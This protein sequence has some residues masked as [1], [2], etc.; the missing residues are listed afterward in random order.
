M[1]STTIFLLIFRQLKKTYICKVEYTYH[2]MKRVV[3]IALLFSTVSVFAQSKA[4]LDTRW[5]ID[6]E[7]NSSAGQKNSDEEVVEMLAQVTSDFR[8]EEL[9]DHGIRIGSRIGNVVTLR[10]KPSQ[11]SILDACDHVIYYQVSHT[12]VPECNDTRFDTRTDSVQAGYGLPQGYDGEGV[13]IGI[14]DWG[15]D[16][17]HPNYNGGGQDN[18]RILRA[19]DHFRHAGPAPEGFDYGTELVGSS[20]LRAAQCDTSGIYGY[21]T[22]GTH[23]TGI[24]A[25]RGI[26][27]IKYTG[28]APKANLLMCSFNLGENPWLDAVAWMKRVADEEGKRLVINS[29]WGMYSF[30]TLDGTSLVSQAIDSY[31]DSG[32]VFVTSAGNNGGTPFHL[33]HEFEGTD[34]TLRSV[35][36][37]YSG[38][39]GNMLIMWGE[40]GERFEAAVG[41]E[42]NDTLIISPFYATDD[43]GYTLDTFLIAGEDTARFIVMWEAENRL[44][45]RPHMDIKVLQQPHVTWHL[46]IHA[47]S[48]FVHAWNLNVQH[49]NAGN[50]GYEFESRN[51]PGY[52]RGDDNYGISE[53]G[54][55]QKAISVAAHQADHYNTIT[56]ILQIG[57][58]ASFSSHGPIMGGMRKPEVSAPGVNVISSLSSFTTETGHTIYD[59]AISGGRSYPFGSMSGTSMSSPAV[60]GVVALILQANPNLTTDQVREILFTT[61]RNDEMTG[62]IH[63]AGELSYI[64][65]WGKVDAYHAVLAAINMLS[66]DEQAEKRM[67]PTAFPNPATNR[68]TLRT[69]STQP[70]QVTICSIDGRIVWNGTANCETVLDLTGWEHGVYIVNVMDN[71]RNYSVKFVKQ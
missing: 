59:N 23:V 60:T 54:C 35:V 36:H 8:F 48:G 28:Q 3:I 70:S 46:F 65:G 52:T 55:A 58:I 19:W 43:A 38:G 51:L 12:V 10:V 63:A 45:H 14:T 20:A 61:A 24:A 11:I 42:C 18:R 47:E 34:D 33:G 66:I 50:T 15:F 39:P 25:G 2:T 56:E 49:N 17:K 1:H 9:T 32:V 13:I 21:G 41:M 71:H 7:W 5:K 30:S 6:H 44:N 27:G 68:L 29:S 26:N 69:G 4:S 64:W 31:S 37:S 22:H 57:D 40:P 67:P 16:Y 53:P 62:N